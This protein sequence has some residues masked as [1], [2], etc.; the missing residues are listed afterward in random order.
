MS[1][2]AKLHNGYSGTERCL[3]YFTDSRKSDGAWEDIR[4][5]AFFGPNVKKK[6]KIYGAFCKGLLYNALCMDMYKL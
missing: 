3:I 6:Q 5:H 1:K 2:P 4:S